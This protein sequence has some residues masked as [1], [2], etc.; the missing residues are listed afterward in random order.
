MA[1]VTLLFPPYWTPAMPHLALPALSSYLRSHGVEVIQ[2]DLNLE[3]FERVLTR[4]YIEQSI[5]R[6]REIG[7]ATGHR[8]RRLPPRERVQWALAEGPKLA[9]QVE[10]AVG[11]MRSPAFLDG[12]T[13]L[14]A[15]YDHRPEPRGRVAAFLSRPRSIC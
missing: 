13:G 15:L 14:Q 12:P 11:V 2:R 10:Q 3:V 8:A 7:A 9:A 5:A 4:E 6:L 1:K